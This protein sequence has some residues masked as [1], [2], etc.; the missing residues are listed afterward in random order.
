MIT[1]A[2]SGELNTKLVLYNRY[3][4]LILRLITKIDWSQFG[5]ETNLMLCIAT[6][7][8]T[9]DS[10]SQINLMLIRNKYKD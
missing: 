6:T 9:L 3:Q 4:K 2:T 7:T 1:I 8:I 10:I 5:S